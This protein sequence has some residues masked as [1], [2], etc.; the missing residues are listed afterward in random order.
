MLPDRVRAQRDPEPGPTAGTQLPQL[1]GLPGLL[2]CLEAGRGCES[3]EPG[4]CLPRLCCYLPPDAQ[5]GL[6]S[7]EADRQ[8][9]IEGRAWGFGT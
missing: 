4:Q 9:G 3:Q 8:H 6:S 5:A 7:P 1:L 2:L